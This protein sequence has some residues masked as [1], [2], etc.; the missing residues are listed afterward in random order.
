M[1]VTGS[2]EGRAMRTIVR[3]AEA[4]DHAQIVAILDAWWGGRRM[5][6]ML[7]MLF[8]VHF[9]PTTFVAEADGRLVG[10]VAGFRSQTH[11]DQAY[12]HFVGVEPAWRGTG[13]GRRLYERF[14]EAAAGLG[15]SEVHCVTSPM[16]EG[17]IAFHSALGFEALAGDS[18]ASGVPFVT[19]YDGPG[20]SRVRFRKRGLMGIGAP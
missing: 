2:A 8:F 3:H 5:A 10:F 9:R 6:D 11:A 13:L 12:I 17:S 20:E 4:A 18:E 15:C 7:P 19:D 16:N 1:D 14:F